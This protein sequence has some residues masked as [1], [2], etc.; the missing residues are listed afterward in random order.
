MAAAFA[1]GWALIRL[2]GYIASCQDELV[3]GMIC[4]TPV[5]RLSHAGLIQ[6]D[7]VG[8]APILSGAF[9]YI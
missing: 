1:F 3:T 8:T 5:K 2:V 4:S 6:W 9:Y 7:W